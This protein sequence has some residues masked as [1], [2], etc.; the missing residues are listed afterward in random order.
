MIILVG[1]TKGG[2]GKST[3]AVNLAAELARLSKDVVLVDADRQL[4][5]HQWI[6]DRPDDLP[7]IHSSIQ[8]D[9]IHPSLLDLAKRYQYVIVDVVGRDSTELRSGMAVADLLLTPFRTSV[10]DLNVMPKLMEIVDQGKILNA[11]L[12]CKSVLTMASP[13]PHVTEAIEARDFMKDFPVFELCKTV[14]RDRKAYRDSLG[15]GRGVV[16]WT[17]NK[18][19]AEIQLLAQE[20]FDVEA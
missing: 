3:L 16:E 20:L 11:N 10:A 17:D 6:Q 19:K 2:C 5:S 12:T 15:E 8:H 4:T 14:I 7:V 18:A 1:N 9:K 13:N